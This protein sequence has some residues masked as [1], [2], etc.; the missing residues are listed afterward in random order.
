LLRAV[1]K[2]FREVQGSRPL[3]ALSLSALSMGLTASAVQTQA[4]ISFP[5]GSIGITGHITLENA[6]IDR[7]I[8]LI[9]GQGGWTC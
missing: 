1:I 5:G 8:H 9:S 3:G 7:S 6:P 4:V 2:V